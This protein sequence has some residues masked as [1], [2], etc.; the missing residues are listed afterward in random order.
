MVSSVVNTEVLT[1]NIKVYILKVSFQEF[2][3]LNFIC[4]EDQRTKE[5]YGCV[6]LH[7][8][9]ILPSLCLGFKKVTCQPPYVN[10][11]KQH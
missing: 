5:I 7:E 9:N 8:D 1:Q 10:K 2:T 11:G 4:L 3:I 6:R